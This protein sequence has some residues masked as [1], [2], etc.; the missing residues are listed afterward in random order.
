MIKNSH[1][2][3][4]IP[5]LLFFST[6]TAFSHGNPP[7]WRETP[8]KLGVHRIPSHRPAT[9]ST[10]SRIIHNPIPSGMAFT[11]AGGDTFGMTTYD[12][13][14]TIPPQMLAA[15]Q[16]GVHFVF[17]KK[18]FGSQTTTSLA[19]NFLDFATGFLFGTMD[20]DIGTSPSGNEIVKGKNN[21][22]LLLASNSS[23]VHIFYMSVPYVW[24]D[25]FIAPGILPTIAAKGDTITVALDSDGDFEG[26]SLYISSQY[27][28]GLFQ[29]K[30]LPAIPDSLS[31]ASA[32]SDLYL[33]GS[34]GV[35]YLTSA[36]TSPGGQGELFFGKSNDAGDSW[37]I[38]VMYQEGEVVNDAVYFVDNFP[39]LSAAGTDDGVHH[40]VFNGYGGHVVP[41]M[42]DSFDYYIYPVV[43]WNDR[44]STFI[45]L[46]SDGVGRNPALS[47]WLEPNLFGGTLNRI[48]IGNAFPNIAT[49]G[50]DTIVVVWE[51][52]EFS[53]APDSSTI[54]PA[55]DDSLGG[56]NPAFAATDIWGTISID[57]GVTWSEPVYLAGAPTKI[58][59]YP[60]VDPHIQY[61]NGQYWLHL[62]YQYDPVPGNSLFEYLPSYT[63]WIY[64]GIP[65]NDFL[66]GINQPQGNVASGFEL[67]QNY[68]NPFNPETRIPYTVSSEHSAGNYP[69]VEVKIYDVLGR[70]V[71][72][73]VKERKA[74]G[75]YTVY[76]DG[77]DGNGNPVSSGVYFYRLRAG[78]TIIKVR[79][80]LLLK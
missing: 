33:N 64:K 38:S 56:L 58:D 37:D 4:L 66:V 28:N 12:N 57:G 71:K 43:Y 68:P 44:D 53:G 69:M 5:V 9:V 76:W 31:F 21:D 11:P 2:R 17:P 24:D 29:G 6:L 55:W 41:N 62:A 70:E 47:G 23:G 14:P 49:L 51:Q 13:Y 73:L 77:R 54:V 42:P 34:S 78:S 1:S 8:G 20:I 18:N 45:E 72:T 60:S 35:L 22:V 30:P 80:M 79:K 26:D 7:L 39:Q 67:K 74:P 61:R 15:T 59:Q 19:Y 25:I 16:E 52:V 48:T 32:T 3:I 75:N 65:L 36:L 40:I 63:W 27:V 50:S 10:I 46:T